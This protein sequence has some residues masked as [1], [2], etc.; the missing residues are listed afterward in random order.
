MLIIN[1]CDK[2][3]L[4]CL[5]NRNIDTVSCYMTLVFDHTMSVE[6]EA[7]VI[8]LQH[9]LPVLQNVAGIVFS[10]SKFDMCLFQRCWP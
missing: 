10:A 1:L 4:E 6:C 8:F 2:F 7:V 9:N 5:L 3:Y